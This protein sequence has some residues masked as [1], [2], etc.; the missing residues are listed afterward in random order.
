M[1]E[2][3]EPLSWLELY[4]QALLELAP[5][6]LAKRLAA[7]EAAMTDRLLAISR[8][9]G[10]GEERRAIHDARQNMRV[11]YEELAS[12]S[13]QE[14]TG[15]HF[16]PEMAGELVAFVDASRRYVSVTDGVCDL[17]GYSRAELLHM[18]I[19]QV[20][21]PEFRET[22]PEAFQRYL[23][24][25]AM[26]GAFGLLARMAAALRFVI[27]LEFFPMDVWWPVGNPWRG[28]LPI[29]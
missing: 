9:A 22:V 1:S 12:S 27:G 7:A 21:D 6:M 3:A 29:R 2:A 13:P 11:L 20:A 19:D 8:E 25:G 10:A 26:E 18:S 24:L 16:H 23:T 17:L 28:R 4:R 15:F 14:Q 5:D